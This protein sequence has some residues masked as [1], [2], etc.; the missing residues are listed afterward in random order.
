ME[1]VIYFCLNRGCIWFFLHPPCD[2]QPSFSPDRVFGSSSCW[3][4]ACDDGGHPRRFDPRKKRW[5]KWSCIF[6]RRPEPLRVSLV[7]LETLRSRILTQSTLPEILSSRQFLCHLSKVASHFARLPW[8]ARI[9]S[10]KS[11]T[12]FP[13]RNSH[14]CSLTL[15]ICSMFTHHSLDPPT[16]NPSP[17]FLVY[18]IFFFPPFLFRCFRFFLSIRRCVQELRANSAMYNRVLCISL[19][20]RVHD[21]PVSHVWVSRYRSPLAT[22][23]A[24]VHIFFSVK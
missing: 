7:H 24:Y 6:F 23:D 18:Y 9:H 14:P 4:R 12:L 10:T 16:N 8:T 3:L 17:F 11:L 5:K 20:V 19:Y 1:S 21:K 15:Q 22:T 13:H 2:L